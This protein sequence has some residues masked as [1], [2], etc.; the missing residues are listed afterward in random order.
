MPRFVF[1]CVRCWCDDRVNCQ[2]LRR[3]SCFEFVLFLFKQP[4]GSNIFI[5]SRSGFQ[6]A[7]RLLCCQ[8]PTYHRWLLVC[9][10]FCSLRAF[11]LLLDVGS[12]RS[13]LRVGYPARLRMMVVHEFSIGVLF[14]LVVW[15]ALS[16]WRGQSSAPPTLVM[17]VRYYQ[18]IFL[19][20]KL[21]ADVLLGPRFERL[22]CCVS[23]TS[24]LKRNKPLTKGLLQ[25]LRVV[26][27]Q[28]LR[29]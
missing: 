27:C 13:S 14:T 29:I 15:K 3:G 17:M 20:S 6:H 8:R 23:Y 28:P 18:E 12:H 26:D 21:R 22:F 11:Y 16:W 5:N 2:R 9:N 10:S 4:S 7:S 19:P 1:V 25:D 24:M